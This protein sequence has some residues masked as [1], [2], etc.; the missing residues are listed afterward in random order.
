MFRL[1]A[2]NETKN[3]KLGFTF[4]NIG[5]FLLASAPFLSIICILI[6][7]F[8]SAF[9]KNEYEINKFNSFQNIILIF[10]SFI[11]LLNSSISFISD[12][13]SLVG[14][15]KLK[16]L[17][18]LFN[19]IPFFIFYF[20]IKPYLKKSNQ[21]EI[22]SFLLLIGTLPVIISGFGQYFFGWDEPMK[23]LNGNIIWFL[24]PIDQ[25][26]GLSGLFSNPNYAASWLS[27]I[28]PF[29]IIFFLKLQSGDIYKRITSLLYI[30]LIFLSMIL[31][32]S[33]DTLIAIILP[34]PIL[35]KST[36]VKSK[37]LIIII[38]CSFFIFLVNLIVPLIKNELNLNNILDIFPRIDIWR[39][40]LLAIFE[41][42]IFGWGASKFPFI[43]D[44]YKYKFIN[45]DIQH[46]HN[47]FFEISLNYG[48]I[49]SILITIFIIYLLIN[50][51]KKIRDNNNNNYVDLAWWLAT[52]SF[53]INQ[54]FDVTY[55][56]LRISM[57]FWVL[58]SGL[59]CI[60]TEYKQFNKLKIKN[61]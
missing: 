54:L 45:D 30:S 61:S 31:T 58:I 22:S 46:A 55:Y 12:I 53:L 17:I 11:F 41:K 9:S 28:W 10:C 24:K 42:P 40:S 47:L 19:W 56:D 25:V 3:F 8:I 60:I 21:R 4:F 48:L 6:S 2:N 15:D 5:I 36:F 13:P 43:Y 32:N 33:K 49:A 18:D 38:I 23:T 20:L 34:I 57:F 27:L 59:D 52:I 1:L 39:V 35:L 44:K 16:I 51:F 29:S 50:S 14:E 7:I 26:K 37:S